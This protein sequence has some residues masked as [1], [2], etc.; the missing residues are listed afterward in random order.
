MNAPTMPYAIPADAS[1]RVQPRAVTK[2]NIK[3]APITAASVGRRQARQR[4][5]IRIGE[6]RVRFEEVWIGPAEHHQQRPGHEAERRS[7]MNPIC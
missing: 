1:V 4:R 7:Q 3:V 2:L 6:P 5:R